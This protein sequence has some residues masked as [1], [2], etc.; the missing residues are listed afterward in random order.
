[1]AQMDMDDFEYLGKERNQI[2]EKVKTT[3]TIFEMDGKRYFQLDTYGRKGRKYPEKI[4]QSFQMDE[5]TAR[6]FIE[7]LNEKFL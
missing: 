4:S 6:R 3:Y 2:Q 1:M 7:L 5:D